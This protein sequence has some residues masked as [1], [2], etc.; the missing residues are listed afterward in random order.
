M[1]INNFIDSWTGSNLIS[2]S[3]SFNKYYK[4]NTFEVVKSH[5][6]YLATNRIR[7]NGFTRG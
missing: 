3:D 1:A 5:V 7:I 2:G 4:V 6:V